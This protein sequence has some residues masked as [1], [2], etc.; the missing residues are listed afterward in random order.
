MGLPQARVTGNK[1]RVRLGSVVVLGWKSA[2]T[3]M[4]AVFLYQH[5]TDLGLQL[6][7]CRGPGGNTEE[8]TEPGIR[9]GGPTEHSLSKG[10]PNKVA[11]VPLQT[12]DLPGSKL[13][14]FQEN[15]EFS[16][17]LPNF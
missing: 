13:S 12:R 16:V 8:C 14:H 10:Q 3:E 2:D 1:S 6:K 7:S 11:I 17:K 15:P 9:L 4:M 5:N